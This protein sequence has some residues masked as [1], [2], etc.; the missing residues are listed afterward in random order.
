VTKTAVLSAL[1][2]K[3]CFRSFPF[4]SAGTITDVFRRE[5]SFAP[6]PVFSSAS[7]ICRQSHF[8][9]TTRPSHRHF[10]DTPLSPV[11]I[12]SDILQGVQ[13][14]LNLILR[15]GVGEQRLASV[16]DM[17]IGID[18][19]VQR[20]QNMM[21]IFLGAQVH[22]IVGLGYSPDEMG[23]AKYKNDVA[24]FLQSAPP[25][26]QES[27]RTRER[28]LWRYVVLTAFGVEPEETAE[29]TIIEARDIMFKVSTTIGE[30]RV[31]EAV[32]KRVAGTTNGDELQHKHTAVQEALVRDVY[33]YG[34]PPLISSLGFDE[35]EEGYI[36]LQVALAEHQ[37]DPLI[38]QYM[39]VAMSRLL[40]AAGVDISRMMEAAESTSGK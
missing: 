17:E 14:S 11:E 16:R 27:H 31:L 32:S 10:S 40:S 35:G 34:V 2:Q 22:T 26:E 8:V 36:R 28:D 29:L 7:I 3:P 6:P 13:S 9:S 18:S 20:W 23:L 21:E 37:G 38:Q 19:L 25:V 5:M 33:F 12:N 24:T 4:S 39:G 15:Y 30:S 1:K